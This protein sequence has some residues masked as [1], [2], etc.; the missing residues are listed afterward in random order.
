[1]AEIERGIVLFVG[2]LPTPALLLERAEACMDG[3]R[4]AGRLF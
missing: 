1:M 2:S 3:G 4:S